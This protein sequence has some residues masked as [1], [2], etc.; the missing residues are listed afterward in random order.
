MVDWRGKERKKSGQ[1]R[2]NLS[3]ARRPRK[4]LKK[5][6]QGDGGLR[7]ELR[8]R[9]R[10]GKRGIASGFE[11]AGFGQFQKRF[12]IA[13]GNFQLQKISGEF[14]GVK[15][16]ESRNEMENLGEGVEPEVRNDAADEEGI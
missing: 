15:L 13:R 2:V 12:Q 6:G 1:K 9:L 14:V 11:R 5:K 4:K 10:K 3:D 7:G 8:K 16:W